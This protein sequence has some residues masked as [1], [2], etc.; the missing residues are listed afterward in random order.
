MHQQEQVGACLEQLLRRSHQ[1]VQDA[2]EADGGSV[3]TG[4]NVD[5]GNTEDILH[6]EVVLAGM[7][8]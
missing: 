8:L 6:Q 3:G 7:Q 2:R 4:T 5:H 1:V